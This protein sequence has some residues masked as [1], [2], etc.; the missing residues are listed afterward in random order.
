M[1]GKPDFEKGYLLPWTRI[2][3]TRWNPTIINYIKIKK[4]A[5][6][7]KW[8]VGHFRLFRWQINPNDNLSD[9]LDICHYVYGSEKIAN[10]L[11]NIYVLNRGLLNQ[12][13]LLKTV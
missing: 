7:K 10:E 2:E 5:K 1:Y 12:V 3:A 9:R 11:K 8:H 13:T 6:S 4:V